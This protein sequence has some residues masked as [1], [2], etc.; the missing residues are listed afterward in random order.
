MGNICRSPT[1]HGILQKII[2][3]NHLHHV[4]EVDSAGTHDYH[5]GEPPDPRSQ[6]ASLKYGVNIS[7]QRS[8]PVTLND[9]KEFDIILAMDKDNKENLL[10]LCP[11]QF[12][13]KIKLLLEYHPSI[14]DK[15]VPDPYY[16]GPE[17]FDLVFQL[18]D[19]AVKNLMKSLGF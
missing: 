9:F 14:D 16:S 3:D 1:A 8:R 10:Q 2:D 18:S 4:L 12:K 15:N 11:H 17:G 13:S 6:K 19:T 7:S 5:E